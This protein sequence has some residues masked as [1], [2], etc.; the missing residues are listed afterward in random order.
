MPH[1]PVLLKEV[2]EFL[3]PKPGGKFIDATFG[4]GG[5]SRAI[6]EKI[7][8]T[9]K[10]LALDANSQAF[11][12]FKF[13]ILN[14]QTIHGNFRNLKAIAEENGFEKVDGILFDLGLSSDM[15]D[16]PERGFSF[17]KNGPL[18][19][20]FDR[21]QKITA[22]DLIN[23]A[24][25]RELLKIFKEYGEERFS[26]SIA[27]AIVEN[28]KEAKLKTTEEL[29]NLIKKSVPGRFRHKAQDSAR[30]IFQA[31]RIEV[32]GELQALGSAL[33]QTLDLLK[34]GGRVVV[35][36][37]HSLEDRIVKKFFQE[38]AKGC[39]CPPEFPQCVC[40]KLPLVKILTRKPITP[41]E[42]EIEQNSRARP[43]KL[44]AIEKI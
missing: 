10:I 27:R 38:A 6:S 13:K 44:R 16:D 34:P 41:T 20:R 26:K 40:G 42:R 1:I 19:M 2:T 25:E 32:N 28:R 29:F 11:E 23:S 17:Q 22:A 30:R 18:D 35:I 43:A 39:V 36:S 14:L 5:H 3:D 31:I 21:S 33:N 8:P 24:T 9:G 7:G 12:N 37:F 4:A 15:L